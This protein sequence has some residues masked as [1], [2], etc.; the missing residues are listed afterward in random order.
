V[1]DVGKP[2]PFLNLRF[3]AFFFF[4]VLLCQCATFLFNGSKFI[5]LFF[6]FVGTKPLVAPPDFSNQKTLPRGNGRV[7]PNLASDFF[8]FWG[9]LFGSFSLNV[10]TDCFG[11]GLF[12]QPA[13][14]KKGSFD[15]RSF[16]IFYL[17]LAIPRLC[18]GA[19]VAV[20]WLGL[21]AM[22]WVVLQGATKNPTST[23]RV[24]C[25][26]KLVPGGGGFGQVFSWCEYI[27][28]QVCF[29]VIFFLL[30]SNQTG[31]Q[32]AS[33]TLL[34]IFFRS[35]PFTTKSVRLLPGG[36][37]VVQRLRRTRQPPNVERFFVTP[38][39]VFL[40]IPGI[41]LMRRP[42]PGGIPLRVV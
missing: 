35:A 4:L 12:P 2:Y 19:G 36:A 38:T 3:F 24:G 30:S 33:R 39:P 18:W 9:Q 25:P 29:F 34:F 1:V 40:R 20:L 5:P 6:W 32:K 22:D 21:C 31:S 13:S 26:R 37:S 7:P 11:P 8:F 41:Q 28:Q 42:A 14:S 16:D 15:P 10:P 23:V 17:P 27:V